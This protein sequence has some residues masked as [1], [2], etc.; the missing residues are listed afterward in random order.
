MEPNEQQSVVPQ[1]SPE[2]ERYDDGKF[3]LQTSIMAEL[4]GIS[5]EELFNIPPEDPRNA[6]LIALS[7]DTYAIRLSDAIRDTPEEKREEIF[8]LVK[9]DRSAA[10]KRFLELNPSLRRIETLH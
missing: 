3:A 10:A 7:S 1:R 8:A 2:E 9:A 5:E 4:L 6:E